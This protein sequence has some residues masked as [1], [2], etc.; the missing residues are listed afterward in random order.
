MLLS[1]HVYRVAV[2]FKMT[3]WVEQWI[4]IKFC[5]KLEHSSMETN[6][7]IQKATAMGNCWLAA[8]SQQHAHSCITS[9]AEFVGKTSSYPGDSAPPQ[10]RFGNLLLLAF[11]KTK[12]IF[13]RVE[14]SD[15]WWDSEKYDGAADGDW[16]NCVRS[17][18][19]YFEG[20]WQC[21]CPMSMF[22]I[23]CIFFNKCLFSTVCG[24]IP[25]GQISLHTYIWRQTGYL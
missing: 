25:S 21:H 7:V 20:E 10:P 15:C 24:W 6:Q 14:I 16:E 11:S 9:C 19:A 13:A 12:I 4:C 2:T 3:E 22:L 1:E 5:V 23:S 8:S 17:Q 18:G